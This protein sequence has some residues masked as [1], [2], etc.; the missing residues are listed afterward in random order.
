MECGA[1]VGFNTQAAIIRKGAAFSPD[2]Y[3]PFL[4][5]DGKHELDADWQSDNVLIV[6]LPPDATRKYRKDERAGS[7]LIQYLGPSP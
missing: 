1:T 6:R 7:I 4:V 2:R 3:P 5:L